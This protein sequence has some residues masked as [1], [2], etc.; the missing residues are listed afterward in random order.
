MCC[1]W[2][3]TSAEAIEAKHLDI[4]H[5]A[6]KTN[7]KEDWRMQALVREKRQDDVASATARLNTGVAAA[8]RRGTTARRT[9]QVSFLAEHMECCKIL[10]SRVMTDN[11]AHLTL[12]LASFTVKDCIWITADVHGDLVDLPYALAKYF[13]GLLH[14]EVD[15]IPEPSQQRLDASLL[16]KILQHAQPYQIGASASSSRT[17][18]LAIYSHIKITHPRSDVH[19]SVVV[20]HTQSASSG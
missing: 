8:T 12:D 14:T 19:V 17:A 3:N 9:C 5:A 4:K 16:H 18:Q 10:G 1:R 13:Q 6:D 15:Y 2:L 11:R 7:Q 20:Y